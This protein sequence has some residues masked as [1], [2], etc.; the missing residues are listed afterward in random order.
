MLKRNHAK[1]FTLHENYIQVMHDTHKTP[2]KN[3]QFY[4][5]TNFIIRPSDRHKLESNGNKKA[6][7]VKSCDIRR[8]T[9]IPLIYNYRI[10]YYLYLQKSLRQK[11]DSKN[12]PSNSLPV[13]QKISNPLCL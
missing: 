10:R 1:S 8:L 2:M 12:F 13:K 4:L 11:R 7:T 6:K 9:W 5:L 3:V